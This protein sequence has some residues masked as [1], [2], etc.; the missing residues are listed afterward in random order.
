M[1][2]KIKELREAAGLTQQQLAVEMGTQQNCVS[3]W[4]SEISLPRARELPKL[5]E[6]LHCTID[7]L[8]GRETENTA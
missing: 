3:N 2:M 5:A 1:V 6:T 8:F 4:E 7:A